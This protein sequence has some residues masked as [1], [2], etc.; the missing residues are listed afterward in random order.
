LDLLQEEGG[1]VRILSFNQSDT[2]LRKVLTHRLTSICTDGLYSPGKPHPR[3]FGTYP[4]L[5]GKYVREKKWLPLEAAIHKISG[6][7]AQRFKVDRRGTLQ[8]GNW[9]DITVF[10]PQEIGTSSTYL[11]PVQAPRGIAYVF[12]NGELTVENNSVVGLPSG[13]PIRNS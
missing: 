11:D 12:V 13:K 3:T 2:N 7:P 6:L 5:L 9:A 8:V 10:D 1:I 4:T